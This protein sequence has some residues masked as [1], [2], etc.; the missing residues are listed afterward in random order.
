MISERQHY[1]VPLKM[2]DSYIWASLNKPAKAIL[3]VLGV[4]ANKGPK[5]WPR[6]ELIAELAGYSDMRDVRKGINDLKEKGLI[7]KVKEGRHNAYFL[8]SLALKEGRQS[9]FPIYKAKMI[10]SKRWAHLTPCEKALYPVLGNKGKINDP[11]ISDT[12]IHALGS[13]DEVKQYYQWAGFSKKSFY[14]ALE[15]LVRHG[16]IEIWKDGNMKQYAIYVPYSQSDGKKTKPGKEV[17]FDGFGSMTML[18]NR[19][20][21]KEEYNGLGSMTWLS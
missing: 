3:P 9:F 21:K 11:D 4:H 10:M 5:V 6:V 1:R 8:S 2:I 13:L 19:E 7:T 14:N 16:L 15:G 18:D 20:D 17:N 12:E